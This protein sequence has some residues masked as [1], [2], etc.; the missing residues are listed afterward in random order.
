MSTYKVTA[1]QT[2]YVEADTAELASMFFIIGD[3]EH[4]GFGC[5]E[6]TE[7]EEIEGE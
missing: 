6:V 4:V 2:Y 5:T 7:V 1:K 3:E